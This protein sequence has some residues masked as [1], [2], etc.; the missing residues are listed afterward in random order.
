M[1]ELGGIT[2]HELDGSPDEQFGE[3]GARVTRRIVCDWGQR[4]DLMSILRGG[5]RDGRIYLPHEYIPNAHW[6]PGRT[7]LYCKEVFARPYQQPGVVP[8]GAANA[9]LGYEYEYAEITVTYAPSTFTVYGSGTEPWLPGQVILATEEIEPAAEFLTLP[10]GDLY[11]GN[12]AIEDLGVDIPGAVIQMMDWVYTLNY[13]TE[14]NPSWLTL[15]G[16]VNADTV[17]SKSLGWSFA[18]N[19]LLVGA[20]RAYREIAS[21]GFG[22]WRVTFRFTYRR[23]TGSAT[24]G[25]NLF[26]YWQNVAEPKGIRWDYIKDGSGNI[27][28][29]YRQTNFNNVFIL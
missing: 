28:Y 20:P 8:A 13:V 22:L 14:L 29:P 6:A 2:Y 3:G 1:A 10:K 5:Y 23:P 18:R 24:G 19:T 17:V 11:I 26:P 4:W 12:Q 27:L 9:A 21:D 16:Y 15:Q 25:W 7:G